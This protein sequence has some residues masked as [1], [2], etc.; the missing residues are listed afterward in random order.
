MTINDRWL[1]LVD[2]RVGYAWDRLL[3]YG[4]GGW[5]FA[6]V[7]NSNVTVAG[8]G[9]GNN[10]SGSNNGWTA[11]AGLEYAVWGTWSVR[12]E[13]DFVRLNNATLTVSPA[14]PKPFAGDIISSNNRQISLLTL[15][16]NY[17]FGGW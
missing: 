2:A 14:A 13:Y 11:G 3:V 1:T 5:A 4:K 7:S 6:G 16:L 15:G 10:G 9:F 17:K 8:T 12:A